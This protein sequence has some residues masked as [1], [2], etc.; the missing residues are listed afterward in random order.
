MR[1]KKRALT[2][3]LAAAVLTASSLACG[4]NGSV[5]FGGVRGSGRLVEEV[6]QV[7]DFTGV[8]LATFGDLTIEIGERE[9][10]RI[11]AESNLIEYF[12]TFVEDDVLRITTRPG[13]ILH[14]RM[15]VK[16]NLIV[17]DLDTILVTGSGDVDGPDLE[18]GH[19]AVT[20][21]GSGDVR[22]GTLEA[23]EV[24]LRITGSGNLDAA[25]VEA[26]E[27]AIAVSGAGDAVL[28]RVSARTFQV[29]VTGAGNLDVRSGEVEEQNVTVSGSGDYR[30]R[31]VSSTAADVRV[32]G[33]GTA[34]IRVRDHLEARVT[35]S[36]DIWYAGTPAVNQSVTGSGDVTRVGG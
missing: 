10:L 6:R 15:P 28:D 29:S 16:F 33:S 11:E 12:E 27:Q 17:K 31:G 9:E 13:V 19:F 5:E 24:E 23:D 34:T 3:L 18:A 30:A 2:M 4:V 7:S 1:M 21:T 36:G 14:T 32:H 22:L 26:P 35:G 25:G 20:I 8:E